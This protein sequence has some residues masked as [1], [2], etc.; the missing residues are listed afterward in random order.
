MAYRVFCVAADMVDERLVLLLD[1]LQRCTAEDPCRH[2]QV[3]ATPMGVGRRRPDYRWRCLACRLQSK[4]MVAVAGN[5]CSGPSPPTRPGGASA[6]T[7][8]SGHTMFN[9]PLLNGAVGSRA[10]VSAARITCHALHQGLERRSARVVVLLAQLC[11]VRAQALCKGV[12]VCTD[13][14]H[15]NPGVSN[16]QGGG[17]C[18]KVRLRGAG[19]RSC[20]GGS[21]VSRQYCRSSI[22]SACK[23]L[24]SVTGV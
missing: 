4:T 11:G 18:L 8:A 10:W 23:G 17:A 7:V 24:I 13:L 2:T 3:V 16:I 5:A 19:R 9:C 14:Q 15:D 6:P 22:P 21:S 12:S 1:G 20:G